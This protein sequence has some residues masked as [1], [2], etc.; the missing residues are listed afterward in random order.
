M[1]LLVGVWT[2]AASLLTSQ[3]ASGFV[4]PSPIQRST[5][6]DVVVGS[7]CRRSKSRLFVARDIERPPTFLDDDDEED[8]DDDGFTVRFLDESDNEGPNSD[9]PQRKG[10]NRWESL[11]PKIKKRLIQEGQARAIANKKKREPA[12]DK[13]RRKYFHRM[14]FVSTKIK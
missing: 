12:A 8:D 14:R 10:Y 6:M 7:S 13:K 4:V 5:P 11:N 3:I 9:T 1:V 2:A